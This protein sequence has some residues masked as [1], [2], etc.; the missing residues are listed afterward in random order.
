M[1][2]MM[3]TLPSAP[4]P[5]VRSSFLHSHHRRCRHDSNASLLYCFAH[6]RWHKKSVVDRCLV[7]CTRLSVRCTSKE[8][9]LRIRQSS[10][11]AT[12]EGQLIRGM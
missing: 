3:R 6:N 8:N 2:G 9:S 11:R 5:E 4:A 12:E 1:I 10:G 7:V